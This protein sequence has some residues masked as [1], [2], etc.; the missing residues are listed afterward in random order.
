[1]SDSSV[2]DPAVFLDAQQSEANVK[3]DPIPTE[4]PDSTDGCYT[5]V[6]GEVTTKS[7]TIGKGDKIGQP[8]ASMV[9]PLKLQLGPQVQAK[10]LSPEFQITDMVFL[11]LTP[12]GSI[13]NGKGRNNAQRAYRTA[14][15]MNNPGEPFSWRA[16]QGKI[17]KVKIKHEMYQESI[18]ERV[19]VVLPA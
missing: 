2:F 12:S 19:A 1:M 6:I 13:D 3:R 7:G 8:W 14:L 4:N 11:D 5:A 16:T 18:Q 15:G 17:V 10:G 9:V